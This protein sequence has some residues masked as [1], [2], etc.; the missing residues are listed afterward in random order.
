MYQTAG[1]NVMKDRTVEFACFLCEIL[2]KKVG[3]G[4]F[5]NI[6]VKKL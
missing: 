5:Y 1:I 6:P 3:R 4:V 2:G